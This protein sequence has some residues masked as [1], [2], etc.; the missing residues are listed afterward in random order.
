MA[1]ERRVA[2]VGRSVDLAD[3]ASRDLGGRKVGP[4]SA[5]LPHLTHLFSLRLDFSR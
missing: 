1:V 5:G 4:R 3:F 2:S